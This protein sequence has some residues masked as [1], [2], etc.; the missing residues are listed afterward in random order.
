MRIGVD[1]GGTKTESVLLDRNGKDIARKRVN[2]PRND[3]AQIIQT[4]VELVHEM[5]QH[6]IIHL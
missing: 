4:I 1:L 6:S 5:E 3:Y 2:T